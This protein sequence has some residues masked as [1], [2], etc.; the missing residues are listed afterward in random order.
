MR[1]WTRPWQPTTTPTRQRRPARPAMFG[2]PWFAQVF[3]TS[4]HLAGYPA[5]V[6]GRERLSVRQWDC[7][8]T[9]KTCVGILPPLRSKSLIYLAKSLFERAKSLISNEG[10]WQKASFPKSLIS[11]S[12]ICFPLLA[13]PFSWRPLRVTPERNHGCRAQQSIRHAQRHG[14]ALPRRHLLS[15]P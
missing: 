4:L 9:T 12:L 5:A 13:L 1:G 6:F 3:S 8:Q 11:R 2:R 10:F 15:V 14:I 7:L